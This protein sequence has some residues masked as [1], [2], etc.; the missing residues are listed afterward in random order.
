MFHNQNTKIFLTKKNLDYLS[1]QVTHYFSTKR[2]FLDYVKKWTDDIKLNSFEFLT[3]DDAINLKNINLMF[4]SSIKEEIKKT[5]DKKYS[6]YPMKV[7]MNDNFEILVDDSEP[8]IDDSMYKRRV[9]KIPNYKPPL[10]LFD[11]ESR[12]TYADSDFPDDEIDNDVVDNISYDKHK[13]KEY[14][15]YIRNN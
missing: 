3:Y 6:N 14:I 7:Q 10:T 5:M 12:N 2:S 1:E 9:L 15:E 8:E 13:M 11:K 4:L